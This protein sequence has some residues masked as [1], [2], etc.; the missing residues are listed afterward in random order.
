MLID[1]APNLYNLSVK[2][3]I[4]LWIMVVAILLIEQRYGIII[5]NKWCRL[6][7][8]ILKFFFLE[9]IVFIKSNQYKESGDLFHLF[10]SAVILTF[11]IYILFFGEGLLYLFPDKALPT[12]TY[13]NGRSAGAC[14]ETLTCIGVINRRISIEKYKIYLNKCK[15]SNKSKFHNTL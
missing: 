12:F 8:F 3:Y 11:L 4:I 1:Q 6:V 2:R 5:I 9:H 15:N 10:I 13:N 7:D 14:I